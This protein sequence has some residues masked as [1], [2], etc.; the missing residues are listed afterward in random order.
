MPAFAYAYVLT[1]I[2]TPFILKLCMASKKIKWVHEIMLPDGSV[3]PG[4][5][6]QK[7]EEWNL[8]SVDFKNKRVLDVGCLDGQYSFFAE[9]KGAREVL[10][11]DII[12]KAKNKSAYPQGAYTNE[13]YL[14]AHKVLK[15]KAKYIFPYSVYNITPEDFGKFDIVLFLGVL[16]HLAHPLLALENINRVLTMGGIVVI[17]TEVSRDF[18]NFYRKKRLNKH[19]KS[20]ITSKVNVLHPKAIIKKLFFDMSKRIFNYEKDIHNNDTS[21][22]WNPSI[23]TLERFIDFSGFEILQKIDDGV[24]SRATYICKK[25]EEPNEIYAVESNYTNYKN[26]QSNSSFKR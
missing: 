19:S 24:S 26:R 16:Y 11:I 17:E 5:W 15:S 4:I 3:T 9:K 14:Y 6:E 20:N 21:I 18:T 23:E 2:F 1:N 8:S 13:A 7:S 22:F 10:S 12:E 25:V